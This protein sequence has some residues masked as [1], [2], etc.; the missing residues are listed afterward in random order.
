MVA[1]MAAITQKLSKNQQIV[2]DALKVSNLPLSAYQILD[3][4]DVRNNGLKAPLT[5][6]RALN[7]LIELGLVHRIE[8]LNAFIACDKEHHTDP[9]AFMICEECKHTIEVGMHSIEKAVQNQAEEQGFKV[10]SVHVEVSG[11]C[12]ACTT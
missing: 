2:L 4:E 11:R 10:C 7:K 5:I 9:P 6:Y 8:S 12:R 3:V 1:G